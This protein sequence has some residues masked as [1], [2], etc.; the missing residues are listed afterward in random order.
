MIVTKMRLSYFFVAK[1][2]RVF[3]GT[4][5]TRRLE[6]TPKFR[7]SSQSSWQAQNCLNV[8]IKVQFESSKH[9]YKYTFEP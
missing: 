2:A 9:L 3:P 4:R 6:K 8:L 5:V 7:Q 1:Q